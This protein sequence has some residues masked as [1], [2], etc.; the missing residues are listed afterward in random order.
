MHDL[1]CGAMPAL[2]A[3][4]DVLGGRG[5]GRPDRAQGAGQDPARLE[6]ALA[7]AVRAL[8]G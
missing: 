2:R 4:L 1:E 8:G 6:E 3:A 7:A 5:G